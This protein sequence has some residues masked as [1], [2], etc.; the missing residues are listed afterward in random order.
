MLPENEE[1]SDPGAKLEEVPL[2]RRV[3][4]GPL[5]VRNQATLDRLSWCRHAVSPGGGDGAAA[6]RSVSPWGRGG[7]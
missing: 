4:F 5:V 2:D 7:L 3:H 6:I 1:L